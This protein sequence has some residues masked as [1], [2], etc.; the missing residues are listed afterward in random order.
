VQHRMADVLELPEIRSRLPEGEQVLAYLLPV[1]YVMQ[2]MIA[3]T[4][5]DWRLYQHHQTL[6]MI[7]DWVFHP[8]RHLEGGHGGMH[9]PGMTAGGIPATLRRIIFVRVETRGGAVTPA[10]LFDMGAPRRP[11]F[12]ADVDLHEPRCERVQELGPGTGWGDV[13]T[14]MF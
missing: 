14:P 11:L 4:G 7:A 2:G 3:D 9:H 8:F 1:D 12:L 5:P 6:P 10:A 13:P